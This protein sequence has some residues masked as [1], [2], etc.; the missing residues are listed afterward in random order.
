MAGNGGDVSRPVAHGR[1]D[2]EFNC[3]SQSRRLLVGLHHSKD[4]AGVQRS[5][6]VVFSTHSQPPGCLH[7]QNYK[8]SGT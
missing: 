4:Q 8:F 2:I 6:R 5:I 1:E 7:L 3:R